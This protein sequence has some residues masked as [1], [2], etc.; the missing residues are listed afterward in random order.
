MLYDWQRIKKIL[1]IE[2][3]SKRRGRSGNSGEKVQILQTNE[4][5]LRSGVNNN[6]ITSLTHFNGHKNVEIVTHKK[7]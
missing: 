2:R 4:I 7:N 5:F 3:E 1:L 6:R